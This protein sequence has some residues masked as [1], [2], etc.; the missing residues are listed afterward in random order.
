ML[1]LSVGLRLIFI[2][3]IALVILLSVIAGSWAATSEDEVCDLNADFALG[4]AD[5]HAAIA[6]HRKFLHSHRD[7]ALAHYHLGFA[8]GMTGRTTDEINEYLAAARLGLDKWDL[9]LNLGLAYLGQNEYPKAINT[10]QIAVLLGPDHPE[11]H[12]NLAIAYERSSRLREALQEVTASL[13][14]APSDPDEHN[15]KAIICAE[16]GDRVCARDEWAHLVQVAPDY[17][18]ARV[19]LAILSGLPRPLAA[20]TSSTLT[21]NGR[22]SVLDHGSHAALAAILRN[23][24]HEPSVRPHD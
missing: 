11:A 16:L 2:V 17:T 24:P 12:F 13:L 6:L 21:G 15:T 5:Y 1:R 23:R 22:A 20:S 10:L 3:A 18:P 7:N 8:Y 4:L 14:L 9:F 19:N